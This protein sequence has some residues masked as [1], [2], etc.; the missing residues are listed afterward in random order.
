MFD[1]VY[2]LEIAQVGLQLGI[3]RCVAGGVRAEDWRSGAIRRDAKNG[4]S[5]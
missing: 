2:A 5:G 4:C 1:I 3:F